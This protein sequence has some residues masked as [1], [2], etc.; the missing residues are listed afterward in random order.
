MLC[1][2][3]DDADDLSADALPPVGIEFGSKMMTHRVV[4]KP[5]L[6]CE[7]QGTLVRCADLDA[8]V[9]CFDVQGQS[10]PGA[11][12]VCTQEGAVHI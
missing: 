5:A 8:F 10:T 7:E 1:N 3:V 2:A 4:V 12:L 6:P 9:R 11:V